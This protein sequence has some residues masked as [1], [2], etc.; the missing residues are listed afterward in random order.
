VITDPPGAEVFL[1]GQ[2]K[3]RTPTSV[4]VPG[5]GVHTLRVALEGHQPWSA[6]LERH[7]PLPDPIR[8]Q[9]LRARRPE[10]G[11][12]RKFFKGMFQK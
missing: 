11:K 3:G 4:Q 12:L 10:E 7:K 5:E 1:D 8:L 9:K 2:T 6:T